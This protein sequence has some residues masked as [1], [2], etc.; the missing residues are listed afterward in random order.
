MIRRL[1][2]LISVLTRIE[3]L[4]ASI[5]ASTRSA[6]AKAQLIALLDSIVT[7]IQDRITTDI[8]SGSGAINDST[9]PVTSSLSVSEITSSSAMISTTVNENGTGFFVV[10]PSGGTAP[11][12][13]QVKAG[14]NGS[15][16]TQ[17]IAGSSALITGMNQFNVTGL[18]PST[19]YTVY[20]VA[21]DVFENLQSTVTSRDFTTLSGSSDTTPPVTS[22][23]SLTGITNTGTMLQVTSN[24][25]GALYIVS[26]LS[27]ATAPTATQVKAWQDA[28]GATASLHGTF[29]MVTGMN[30]LNLTGFAPATSYVLYLVAEDTSGNLQSTVTSK[31]F[32][33]LPLADT[34]PPVITAISL[35]GITNSGAVLHFNTSEQ[36]LIHSVTLL[37]GATAPTVVQVK[38]GEDAS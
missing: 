10:T 16:V 5:E 9:P 26:L 17:P 1:D 35:T 23:I 11:T 25:S 2:F 34:T 36:G 24:E 13:A 12:A 20:F 19:A 30:Q 37:S 18:A 3:T 31:A 27:G 38:A 15:G 22:A 32:S 28:S 8:G 14:Q 33:T 4:R 21:E 6:D 29:T 7:I